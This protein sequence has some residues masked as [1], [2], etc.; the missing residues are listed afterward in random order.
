MDST[1]DGLRGCGDVNFE[2]GIDFFTTNTIFYERPK[3]QIVSLILSIILCTNVL[4]FFVLFN[5]A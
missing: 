4:A 1:M 5:I 2:L 3:G